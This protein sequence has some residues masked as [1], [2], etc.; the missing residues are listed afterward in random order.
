MCL[1]GICEGEFAVALIVQDVLYSVFISYAYTIY[2]YIGTV[3]MAYNA[4][5]CYCPNEEELCEV[6]CIFDG[7][8]ISTFDRGG[9]RHR[10]CV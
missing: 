7:S 6:C 2:S 5:S 3:C 10:R 4:T 1:G 8:C 9:R